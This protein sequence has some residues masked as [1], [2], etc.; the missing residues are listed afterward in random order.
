MVDLPATTAKLEIYLDHLKRGRC[1]YGLE[2]L[3][4]FIHMQV[5]SESKK[6][7]I[8]WTKMLKGHFRDLEIILN[9][10]YKD[11]LACTEAQSSSSNL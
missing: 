8:H 3:P 7:Q 4:C 2:H 1:E 10:S 11:Y 6:E 9:L 5:H